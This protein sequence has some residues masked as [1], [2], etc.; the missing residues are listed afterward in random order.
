MGSSGPNFINGTG[1]TFTNK[2]TIT[3]V[4]TIGN[5]QIAL[6]NNKTINANVSGQT[7]LLNPTAGT[8]TS[9]LEATGGGNLQ[10]SGS[11]TNSGT[12]EALIGSTATLNGATFLGRQERIGSVAVGKN[13]DLYPDG[14][15][16]LIKAGTKI[17]FEGASGPLDFNQ[18]HNVFGPYAA[19]GTDPSSGVQ[20]PIQTLTAADL[21]AAT[22]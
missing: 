4:G 11:F 12:I 8:N 18:Y 1:G 21:A 3:G 13:A 9:I 22:P 16:L 19:F 2:E 15:G 10:L 20:S 14:T 6:V 5:G 17:N 7:L